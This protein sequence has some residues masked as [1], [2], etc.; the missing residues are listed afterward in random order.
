M[1]MPPSARTCLLRGDPELDAAVLGS[2]V[3]CLVARNRLRLTKPFDGHAATRDATCRQIICDR[4]GS[5]LRQTLVVG[6]RA[7]RVGM[8]L[9][10]DPNVGVVLEYPDCLVE[11][12]F[13]VGPDGRLVEVEVQTAQD[14]LLF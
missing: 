4:P 14:D 11:H 12:G 10:R 3:V 7:N 2:S 5:A 9:D 13:S 1:A 8:A 6:I